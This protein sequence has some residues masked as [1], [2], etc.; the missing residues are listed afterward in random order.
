MSCANVS[1]YI[2]IFQRSAEGQPLA[3]KGSI[4]RQN[5]DL[6]GNDSEPQRPESLLHSGPTR[7]SLNRTFDRGKYLTDKLPGCSESSSQPKSSAA[8]GMKSGQSQPAA[9][10]QSRPAFRALPLSR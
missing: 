6:S 7:Q 5:Q 2:P 9:P 3:A 8:Q 10:A 4:A 1:G